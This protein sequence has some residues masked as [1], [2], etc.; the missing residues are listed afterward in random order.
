MFVF[1]AVWPFVGIFV[2]SNKPR[3][4]LDN[5]NNNNNNGDD[6]THVSIDTDG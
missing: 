2:C 4:H 3:E 1:F 5:I 6:V